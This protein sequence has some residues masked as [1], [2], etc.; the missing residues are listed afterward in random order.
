MREISLVELG[1]CSSIERHKSLDHM[2]Y[3]CQ[4]HMWRNENKSKASQASKHTDTTCA[5]LLV[6]HVDLSRL[7][8]AHSARPG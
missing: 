8:F 2:G 7:S 3:T 5:R 1:N 6:K 4:Q